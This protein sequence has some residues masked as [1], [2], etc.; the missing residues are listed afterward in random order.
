MEEGLKAKDN[1]V[2]EVLLKAQTTQRK[3][4]SRGGNNSVEEVLIRRRYKCVQTV[5]DSETL[6]GILRDRRKVL[7][8]WGRDV[9][10]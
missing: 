1:S 7:T 5:S 10:R 9:A 6:R 8:G 3:C 2:E 4:S